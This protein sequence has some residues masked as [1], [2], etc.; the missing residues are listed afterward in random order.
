MCCVG[1]MI[2]HEGGRHNGGTFNNETVEGVVDQIKG[3]VRF[4]WYLFNAS[5]P[6]APR[7]SPM[8]LSQTSYFDVLRLFRL[9]RCF[10][11]ALQALY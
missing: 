3:R 9:N 7:A 2:A 4:A 6:K 8:I 1:Q 10:S 5:D 11:S